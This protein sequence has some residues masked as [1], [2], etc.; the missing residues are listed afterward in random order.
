MD[1]AVDFI[2]QAASRQQFKTTDASRHKMEDL[3]IACQVK[4]AVVEQLPDV[5]VTS[6][7]GNVIIFTKAQERLGHKL[8]DRVNV[9]GKEIEGINNLEIHAG[10]PYP[11][12]AV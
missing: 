12:N 6:E 4:A 9:L 7:Y 2:C 10:L 3:A 1:D 11:P 5:A 8:K